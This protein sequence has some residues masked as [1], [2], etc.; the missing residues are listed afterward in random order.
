MGRCAVKF[1]Q[2]NLGSNCPGEQAA[3]CVDL[4]MASPSDE[5]LAKSAEAR[6][7]GNGLYKTGKLTQGKPTTVTFLFLNNLH[8]A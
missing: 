5:A 2:H 4:S 8:F 1:L 3:R 7:K 6:E